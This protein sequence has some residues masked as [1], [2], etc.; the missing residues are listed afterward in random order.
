MPGIPGQEKLIKFKYLAE[1]WRG[2]FHLSGGKDPYDLLDFRDGVAPP[3]RP[4][5]VIVPAP[6]VTPPPL[7]FPDNLSGRQIRESQELRE[8]AL[9]EIVKRY[10]MTDA[11]VVTLTS[12]SGPCPPPGG[13]VYWGVKGRIRGKWHIWQAG[14]LGKP[15]EGTELIDPKR[16][17]K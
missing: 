3:A 6:P 15:R 9:K 2:T 7:R 11:S 12:H 1:G 17:Q 5:P 8:R 14:S 13:Y 4:K 10:G 16:Y